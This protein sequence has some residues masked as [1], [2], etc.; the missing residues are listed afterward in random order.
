MNNNTS[1]WKLPVG[2]D[3]TKAE[4]VMCDCGSIVYESLLTLKKIPA[5][6]SP[7]GEKAVVPIPIFKCSSCGKL[8]QN[9][10]QH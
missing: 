5:D 7:S 6:I 2:Y 9:Y 10:N 8:N 1:D 4:N 3:I